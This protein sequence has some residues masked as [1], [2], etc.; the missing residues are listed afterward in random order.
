MNRVYQEVALKTEEQANLAAAK[1][2]A[3]SW[4]WAITSE[5]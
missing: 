4:K 3:N 1:A 2:T 5:R